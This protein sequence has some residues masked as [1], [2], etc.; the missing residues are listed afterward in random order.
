MNAASEHVPQSAIWGYGEVN[1]DE[2]KCYILLTAPVGVGNIT[3]GYSRM[4]S[5]APIGAGAP[6]PGLFPDS[7]VLPVHFEV[8]D[9]ANQTLVEQ[10]LVTPGSFEVDFKTR[11]KYTVYITNKGNETSPMPIGVSFEEGKPENREADK[12][13]LS[14]I[15]T[16]S[17]AALIF[18]G[19]VM[20][21]LPKRH[22]LHKP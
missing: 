1:V 10:D 20:R 11:G 2:T 7:Y 12:Y 15:L 18:T 16:A 14:I 19:L 3:V 13:L 21:L 6:P 8:K 4:Q 22:K 5:N 9:P 17:G